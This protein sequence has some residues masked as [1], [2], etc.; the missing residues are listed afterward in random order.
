[1]SIS[2]DLKVWIGAFC[3]LAL[4]SVLFKE[5]PF[6][7][8]VENAYVGFG[9]AHA[10]V[11]GYQNI[12]DTA[13]KP[14]VEKGDYLMLVPIVLGL[15][16][17]TRLF[18]GGRLISVLPTAFIYG[19][20]VGIT[21]PALVKTQVVDQIAQTIMVPKS[22]NDV[23]MLVGVIITLAYFVFTFGNSGGMVGLSR[24]G[25]AFIMLAFGAQFGNYVMGRA[26][27]LI[28]RVYFL[29]SDWLGIVKI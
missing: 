27:E 14:L 6:F 4:L 13:W 1:M 20:G 23:I 10:L 9:G 8:I 16:L 7:R 21:L 26:A 25:R 15:L 18:K 28:G 3:T 2:S 17:Y 12:R 24:A 22:L 5:N 29:L 11:V 19:L